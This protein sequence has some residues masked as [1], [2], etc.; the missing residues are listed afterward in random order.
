[1]TNQAALLFISGPL[2][3]KGKKIKNEMT[4]IGR[5]SSC[6]ICIA[7]A[8]IS[9]EH[10][11]IVLENGVYTI[12]DLGSHNGIKVNSEKLDQLVLKS[13]MRFK[14][15]A[16]EIEFWDGTGLAPAMA[17]SSTPTLGG[18]AVQAIEEENS[19][20]SRIDAL[21]HKRISNI[22]ILIS[23]ISMFLILGFL[24]YF[25][26]NKVE[27]EVHTKF[28]TM[29]TDESRA[30]DL[31]FTPFG[32]KEKL[33]KP[34]KVSDYD[35][36]SAEFNNIYLDK[37]IFIL[38]GSEIEPNIQSAI[39]IR[40]KSKSGS[41]KI[42]FY[43]LDKNKEKKIIGI[44]NIEVLRKRVPEVVTKFIN[45]DIEVK[46]AVADDMFQKALKY[47]ED[48]NRSKVVYELLRDGKAL[49]ENGEAKPEIYSKIE[50][51]LDEI[52]KKVERQNKTLFGQYDLDLGRNDKE[53]CAKTLEKIILIN[54]DVY[55][56]YRQKAEINL[57]RIN[58]NLGRGL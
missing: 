30:I 9:R 6:D 45:S 46:I 37:D 11:K 36:Y 17:Q 39:V 43:V 15:G 24:V 40:T 32:E 42:T 12:K 1:M 28:F 38:K 27:R 8:S 41:G 25:L 47:E 18:M 3:G 53:S 5:S 14:L 55:N 57:R 49:F 31:N 10:A 54:P 16:A 13:G 58:I 4:I 44:L 20:S 23:I 35:G 33:L 34:F 50:R 56:Y 52:S 19:P 7:D 21:R 48:S 22:I 51:K 29:Y 2:A 26:L